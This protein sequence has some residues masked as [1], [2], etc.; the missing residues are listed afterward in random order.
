MMNRIA[1]GTKFFFNTSSLNYKWCRTDD[2]E[3]D[4]NL[5]T[6]EEI[7]VNLWCLY[8]CVAYNS[9]P[10]YTASRPDKMFGLGGI[11]VS[12]G[13]IYKKK[14]GLGP[15]AKRKVLEKGNSDN[16]DFTV[17][18]RKYVISFDE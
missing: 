11:P 13:H 2:V 1:D 18:G 4:H 14:V 5:L 10:L 16:R 12:R 17:I 8:N 3:K 6:K 7:Q 15:Q 9:E